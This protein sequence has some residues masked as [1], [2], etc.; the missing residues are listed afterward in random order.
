MSWWGKVLG[1]TFGF[2][3]GGPIGAVVGA[4]LG[5]GFDRGAEGAAGAAFSHQERAQ[6]AFFTATF[7]VMGHIAK[8]DGRVTA[9][10]IRLADAVM[11][12][13]G[14]DREQRRVAQTLFAQGKE[15]GFPLEEVLTQLRREC[16]FGTNLLQ[17]FVEIQLQAALADGSVDP[18][19]RRI[20][21]TVCV[22][23]GFSPEIL[24]E[25]ERLLRGG[26][27]AA[28]SDGPSV[29]EARAI[30][31]VGA[32]TGAD[33]IKRAYRRQMNRHHPDK[34]IAKGLP[35]EMVREATERSQQIR[36]AYD[37]LK[38]AR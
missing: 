14:L 10:E 29:D 37:R 12:R 4:A 33:D 34:L 27:A 25:V 38:Q 22:H 3:V 26:A 7:S 17:V 20:L 31:G 19:E 21:E 6:A 28:R 11:G 8:A 2:M 13:F 24:D 36:A 35:E 32:D 1:G 16:R 9:E 15:P 30:L 5:H 18:S 23:L